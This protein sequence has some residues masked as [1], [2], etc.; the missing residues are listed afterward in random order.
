[1]CVPSSGHLS[2]LILHLPF[3]SHIH[4]IH[5]AQTRH[6]M[7]A[8]L[9]LSVGIQQREA[10]HEQS[11]WRDEFISPGVGRDISR[12]FS[13]SFINLLMSRRNSENTHRHKP[14]STDNRNV[15][16]Y[17]SGPAA[18]PLHTANGYQVRLVYQGPLL[19]SYCDV[20]CG[21]SIQAF[22]WKTF[23]CPLKVS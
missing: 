14:I 10:Q 8:L 1:M 23:L 12:S 11:Q 19:A 22:V 13:P 3:S 18:G 21:R 7:S 15:N 5:S 20:S 17:A 4:I 2:V 6:D 16:Y 9:R